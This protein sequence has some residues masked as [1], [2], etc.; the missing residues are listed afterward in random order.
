MPGAGNSGAGAIEEIVKPYLAIE[1]V[2][3]VAL[4]SADGLLVV[5]AGDNSLDLEALAAN[6]AT[7]LSSTMGMAAGGPN[8]IPRFIAVDLSDRGLILAPLSKELLLVLAGDPS[9]LAYAGCA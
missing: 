3:A 6:A 8:N 4:V 7:A 1:G 5:S 9:I 2:S